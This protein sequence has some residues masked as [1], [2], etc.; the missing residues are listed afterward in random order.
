MKS[1]F[2]I[3]TLNRQEDLINCLNSLKN[4]S[5][6]PDEIILIEQW[7][8]QKTED[9]IKQ[10]DWK[11][12]ITLLYNEEKSGAKARNKWITHAEWEYIF[13]TDDDITFDKKYIETAIN[14]LDKNPSIQGI[15][16]KELLSEKKPNYI[17]K[18]IWWLFCISTLSESSKILRSWH[19]TSYSSCNEERFTQS[20]CWCSIIRKDIFKKITFHDNFIKRSFGEDV[21]LSHR[22]YKQYWKQ[23]LKYLPQLKY[24]HFHSPEGRLANISLIRMKIIYRY[25]FWKTE[26]YDNNILNLFCYIW[27][28]FWLILL[29]SLYKKS[30]SHIPYYYNTYKYLIR[31]YTKIDNN[32][33]DYNTYINN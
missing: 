4:S 12:N 6:K 9:T 7:N 27:S 30:I 21:F 14:F 2:I 20:I 33:I 29:E 32:S 17:G 5:I 13:F 19:N 25:I 15:T 18:L 24:K 23:S 11:L 31:N 10:F 1:S 22:I 28:Q 26:V 3:P 16:G 8:L